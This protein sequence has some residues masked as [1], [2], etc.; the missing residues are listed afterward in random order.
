MININRIYSF[1]G[2]H[3]HMNLKIVQNSS[4]PYGSGIKNHEHGVPYILQASKSLIS[5]NMPHIKWVNNLYKS[6]YLTQII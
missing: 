1:S 5:S 6:Y 3:L 4:V 2:P